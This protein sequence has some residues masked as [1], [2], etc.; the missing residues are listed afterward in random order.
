MV[1]SAAVLE[2]QIIAAQSELESLRQV[3]TPNNV[4]V[5]AMQARVDELKR[6]VRRN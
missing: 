3:Y 6:A 4:R 1:E 2:G 5:R